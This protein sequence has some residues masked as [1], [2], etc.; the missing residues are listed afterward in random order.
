MRLTARDLYAT[1]L[2]AVGFLL[3]LSVIQD[4]SWPLLSNARSGILALG[5]A[6]VAAGLINMAST[7]PSIL[8]SPLGLLALVLGAI[9]LAAVIA[10][11]YVGTKTYLIILMA[12]S[13]LLVASM[14][15]HDGVRV[16]NPLPPSRD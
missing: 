5:A 15:V 12:T 14:L 9:S 10:G 1:L 8:K 6:V 3:A 13:L 2:V 11:L 4:W 7:G 16:R